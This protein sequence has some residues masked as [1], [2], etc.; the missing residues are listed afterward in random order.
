MIIRRVVNE[1][2]SGFLLITFTETVVVFPPFLLYKLHGSTVQTYSYFYGGAA[3]WGQKLSAT[4]HRLS[5]RAEER[6]WRNGKEAAL[7]QY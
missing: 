3:Q 1:M 6:R 2:G 4:C 5:E 7:G